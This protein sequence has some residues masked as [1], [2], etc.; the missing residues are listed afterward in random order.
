MPPLNPDDAAAVEVVCAGCGATGLVDRADVIPEM[1]AGLML[2]EGCVPK[3]DEILA[4]LAPEADLVPGGVVSAQERVGQNLPTVREVA[5]LAVAFARACQADDMDGSGELYR[6]L[7]R[8]T[9][10][11]LTIFLGRLLANELGDDQERWE[12]MRQ[13]VA[14]LPDQPPTHEG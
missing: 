10:M 4:E 2:C 12:R 3:A 14:E 1:L 7:P 6:S 8:D 5:E 9:R 13:W 11:G